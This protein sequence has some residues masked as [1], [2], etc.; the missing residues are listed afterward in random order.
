MLKCPICKILL[1]R[2]TYEGVNIH[3]C[4]K[5]TGTLLRF[6]R[7]RAVES[8]RDKSEQELTNELV[9]AGEDTLE[10]IRCSR[11]LSN[12][13]KRT[14]KLGSWEFTIDR[15]NKCK[16]VW[17]DAG[18]LAKLQVVYEYSEKGEEAKRF[19]NRLKNM[20]PEEKREYEARIASLKEEDFAMDVIS[21]VA[22]DWRVANSIP[23][24]SFFE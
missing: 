9:Q 16:L 24:W 19:Q 15:C 11:C 20:S 7:L 2:K 22:T 18:E 13:E 1:V 12:M 3:A 14:K 23:F 17:L 6:D 21:G 8:R 4:E 5:C 10:K